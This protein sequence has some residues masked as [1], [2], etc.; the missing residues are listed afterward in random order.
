MSEAYVVELATQLMWTAAMLA[1]E[2]DV[3]PAAPVAE[4]AQASEAPRTAGTGA[5]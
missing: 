3:A 5:R 2:P 4:A 1:A